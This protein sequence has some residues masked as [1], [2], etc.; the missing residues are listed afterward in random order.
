MT[1]RTW[2]HLLHLPSSMESVGYQS[3]RYMTASLIVATKTGEIGLDY[4]RPVNEDEKDVQRQVFID[5]I[6][7]AVRLDKAVT[8]HC[9]GH[10]ACA[11]A[12]SIA[13]EVPTYIC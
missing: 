4:S 10:S 5:K 9:R 13:K 3:I 8:I 6:G 7:I 12:L 2:Q 1:C 11:D